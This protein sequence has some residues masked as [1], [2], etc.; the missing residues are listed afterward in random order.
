[1]YHFNLMAQPWIRC[2]STEGDLQTV[3]AADALRDADRIAELVD[4]DPL[5]NFG[6]YRFLT[7]LLHWFSPVQGPDD[8]RRR[9]ASWGLTRPLPELGRDARFDLFDSESPFYQ[10]ASAATEQDGPPD[11]P[12]SYLVTH[13]PTGRFIQHH[14]HIADADWISLCP[15]CCARALMTFSPFMTIGGAG[16]AG[17]VNSPPPVYIL[18]RGETLAQTLLLNLPQESPEGDRPSWVGCGDPERP[19]GPLEGLTWQ[20]RRV[21]L[22]P[23]D[24]EGQTCRWCG[25]SSDVMV[26]RTVFAPGRKRSDEPDRAWSDPHAVMRTE[27]RQLKEILAETL[28]E[29]RLLKKSVLGDGEDEA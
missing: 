23:E 4:D 10:D 1:M 14:E 21:L 8:W 29:N 15:A 28:L 2:R 11:K 18:P 3:T 27:T 16:F 9:W 12:A 6:L 22:R 25:R 7:A 13:F 26:S 5:V 17:S 24:G 20:C 19:I